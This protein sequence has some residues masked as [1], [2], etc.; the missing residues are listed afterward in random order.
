MIGK[1]GR[2]LFYLSRFLRVV[3]KGSVIN[4]IPNGV[5]P[6]RYGT[7]WGDNHAVRIDRGF[8]Q[9]FDRSLTCRDLL[10][11][12]W[13]VLP[14]RRLGSSPFWGCASPEP[15]QTSLINHGPFRDIEPSSHFWPRMYLRSV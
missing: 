7:Y 3:W 11:R 6:A 4:I 10:A 13:L 14:R 9:V 12:L 15:A 8:R 5:H 1:P 2:P